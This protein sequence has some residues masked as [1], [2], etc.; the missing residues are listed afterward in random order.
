MQF[1][2]YKVVSGDSAAGEKLNQFLRTHK[3][4]TVE[5]HFHTDP[6]ETYWSFCIT[7]LDSGLAEPQKKT[8]SKIDYKNELSETEFSVFSE[9]RNTRKALA[10]TEGIPIYAVA[11]NAQLAAMIRERVDSVAAFDRIRGFGSVKTERFGAKFLK[12]LSARIPDLLADE[13]TVQTRDVDNAKT[14]KD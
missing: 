6:Q 9:L 11:T 12:T 14:P 13:P 2:F 5:K 7:W 10:E 8:A 3:T 1:A 4:L